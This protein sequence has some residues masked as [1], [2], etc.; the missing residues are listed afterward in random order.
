[1]IINEYVDIKDSK[2][3]GVVVLKRSD[4]TVVFKKDNLIVRNGRRY[5]WEK[6][7]NSTASITQDENGTTSSG[8]IGAPYTRQFDGYTL[9]EIAFGSSGTAT[10]FDQQGLSREYTTNIVPRIPLSNVGLELGSFDN[11]YI[12]IVARV[13][14]TASGEN[15]TLAEIGLFLTKVD[16]LTKFLFSRVVFDPIPIGSGDVYEVEYYIYF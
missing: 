10:S 6:F 12:K 2:I 4:G 7:M 3:R 8:T 13:D 1:M 16:D 15:F 14:N 5:L 9:G 11:P